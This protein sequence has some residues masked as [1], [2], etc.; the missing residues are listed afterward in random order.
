MIEGLFD[1]VQ[2]CQDLSNSI[3]EST[4]K[5]SS[6]PIAVYNSKFPPILRTYMAD[7]PL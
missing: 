2:T 7:K 1:L 6:Q 4:S 3:K 5:K